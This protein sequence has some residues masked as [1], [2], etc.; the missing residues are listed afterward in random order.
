MSAARPEAEEPRGPWGGRRLPKA[1]ADSAHS[2]DQG[3]VEAGE[4]EEDD[5]PRRLLRGFPPLRVPG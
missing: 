5:A 3:A 1:K 4:A 2:G